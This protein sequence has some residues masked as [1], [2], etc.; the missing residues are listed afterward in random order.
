VYANDALVDPW[1]VAQ[2]TVQSTRSSIPLVAVHTT[3]AHPFTV[4]KTIATFASL[5]GRQLFVHWVAGGFADEMPNDE[6]YDRLVEFATIVRQ[7]TDGATVT[8]EGRYHDARGLRLPQPVDPALRP[9]FVVSGSSSA[10]RVASRALQARSVTHALP[11]EEDHL[12]P[13]ERGLA[14]ALRLGIIARRD[15]KEAWQTAYT[16]FSSDRKRT[17][18]RHSAHKVPMPYRS[19]DVPRLA[20]ER[21]GTGTPY[22]TLPFENYQTLCP[23]LVGSHVDVSAA[24][25][26]Y[27]ERGFGTFILDEPENE[28]DLENA[29]V[30]FE[31]ARRNILEAA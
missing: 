28:A 1:L 25:S 29:R 3:H 22:W 4:A 12:P 15:E 31:N 5:Y 11:P 27:V 16:R 9:E 21:A 17:P 23:Y 19:E 7:L 20:E 6:R 13:L 10:G 8:L 18:T 14:S 26:R 2:V 24:L 30:V